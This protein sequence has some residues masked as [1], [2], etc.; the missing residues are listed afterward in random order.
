MKEILKKEDTLLKIPAPTFVL[1]DLHGNYKDLMFFADAFW[2]FGV[3][4]CPSNLLFLVNNN[5]IKKI[6]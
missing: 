6:K 5:K 3:H 2:R 1:G 4:L